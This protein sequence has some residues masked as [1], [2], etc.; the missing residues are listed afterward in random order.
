MVREPIWQVTDALY[1]SEMG[2]HEDLHC[3]R[4]KVTSR[5]RAIEMSNLDESE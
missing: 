5:H 2:S 3:V 1:S 4:K